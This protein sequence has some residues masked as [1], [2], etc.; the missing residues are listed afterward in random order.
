[1]PAP[2]QTLARLT[3]YLREN[4]EPAE[5]LGPSSRCWTNTPAS[6]SSSPMPCAPWPEP[7]RSTPPS[8]TPSKPTS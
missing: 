1:M 4:P 3:E 2:A 5:A 8:L 7:C 6:P